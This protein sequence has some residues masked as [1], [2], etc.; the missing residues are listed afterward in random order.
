MT[1]H[2]PDARTFKPDAASGSPDR[3]K[4]VQ[5]DPL[6]ETNTVFRVD[7]RVAETLYVTAAVNT[8]RDVEGGVL[9]GDLNFLCIWIYIVFRF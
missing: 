9:H 4:C 2:E 5:I 8:I 6:L 7:F 1:L 3:E